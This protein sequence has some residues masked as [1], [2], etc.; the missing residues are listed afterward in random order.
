MRPRCTIP[1]IPAIL[2]AAGLLASGCVTEVR[3]VSSPGAPRPD[4]TAAAQLPSTPI[5]RPATGAVT[6]TRVRVAVRPIGGIHY[7]GVVLPLVSPDGRFL[8]VQEGTAPTW[9]TLLAADNAVVPLGTTLVIYD[10]HAVPVQR[11]RLPQALPPGLMLGRAADS[12]GFL[13][14]SP[15]VEGG[16]WIGKVA[17][18]SGQLQWLVQG[19]ATNAHAVVTTAGELI[20]TR[21]NSGHPAQ[22][23]LRNRQGQESVRTALDGDYLFPIAPADPA[24]VYALIGTPT[25]LELEAIGLIREPEQTGPA[26]FGATL[27]RSNI[28]STPDPALAYQIAAPTQ[29]SA[30]LWRRLAPEAPIREPE[31]LLIFHPRLERMAALDKSTGRFL[32]LAP[33]SIAAAY[34]NIPGEQGFFC[35]APDGLVFT[36]FHG[37]DAPGDSRR[38]DARVLGGSYVPR[39]TADPD[40]PFVLLGP[41]RADPGR[42]ELALM[43]IVRE[44]AE[45]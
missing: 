1:A 19:D 42:L 2:A 17:W 27:A 5:A 7:D 14:E 6:V 18:A 15:R 30:S 43:T 36:P 28:V 11:L 31:P 21:R 23:V 34:W 16:R 39:L 9:P 45:Q 37:F 26:R 38:A 25:G 22:L 24:A 3:P 29:N 32:P 44:D 33:K 10:L 41:S 40:R 20:Y 13:V 35:T 12:E 8:A 4:S